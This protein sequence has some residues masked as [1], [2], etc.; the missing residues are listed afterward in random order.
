MVGK[1]D[2]HALRAEATTSVA[3]CFDSG[4]RPWGILWFQ[5]SSSS[6]FG[7]LRRLLLILARGRGSLACQRSAGHR[8]LNHTARWVRWVAFTGFAGAS[9]QIVGKPDSHALRAEA[10]TAVAACFDSGR[11]RWEPACWRMRQPRRY[12]PDW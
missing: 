12:E 10:T 2:S 7:L 3:A 6:S 8:Q 4:P 9:R 5:T 1:P 11:R